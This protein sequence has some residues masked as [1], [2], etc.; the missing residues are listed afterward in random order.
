MIDISK[1]RF[2]DKPW[3]LVDGCTPCSPG[4]EHCWAAGLWNRF[5]KTTEEGR[6]KEWLTD[7]IIDAS[8]DLSDWRK[9]PKRI[10]FNGLIKTRPER[11]AIP[12]KRK[13]PT[14]YAVWNDLFHEAIPEEFQR[15]AFE[16]MRC[17]ITGKYCRDHTFLILTKRPQI[18]ADFIMRL[19][20]DKGPDF[21]RWP[22]PWVYL[23]LTICNQQEADEKI[24]IFLQVPGKKFLS[25]EPMLSRMSIEKYLWLNAPSTAGPWRD[26]TGKVVYRGS[27]VGGQMISSTPSGYI[28]A[29]I[30]GGETG[31]SAR[32]MHPDWVR[33][34][35]D[36][37][38]AAG[39]PFFF[40]G[41]GRHF[42]EDGCFPLN[43]D[44]LSVPE[45][46]G[47][48]KRLGMSNRYLDGRTHDDLPWM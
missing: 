29:V 47:F 6:E 32:P 48:M 34:V 5:H 17:V 19:K 44:H 11:L 46:A 10:E 27:G 25:I 37:C 18:I 36:Q 41:W 21:I 4:C 33:S 7:C 20:D 38:A 22:L 26:Y 15:Q 8:G 43:F 9:V 2:W 12:M 23:G 13:K 28:D 40:K 16:I 1:G 45:L 14:V 30:L 35:R 42:P 39:V 3:S 31:P 24:P